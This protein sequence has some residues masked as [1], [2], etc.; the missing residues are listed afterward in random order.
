MLVPTS[1]APGDG[2][3]E[4]S[5]ES[6]FAHAVP[7]NEKLWQAVA[8][9]D[10]PPG[11]GIRW[12]YDYA[13]LLAES[14]GKSSRIARLLQLGESMQDKDARSPTYGNFRWYWRTDKVT[15][16]NAVEFVS[17]HMIP[18]WITHRRTLDAASRTAL[19]RTLRRAV[20][21]CLR[22][23]VSSSY[24]NIA[25]SNAANLI[26]L[27]EQ[28]DRKDALAKGLERLDAVCLTTWRYGICEYGS[29]TY[30][31]VDLDELVLLD[32]YVR[33][34]RGRKAAEAMLEMFWTD[35]ALNFFAP[36]GLLGGSQSRSYNY[37]CGASDFLDRHLAQAGWVKGRYH[38]WTEGKVLDSPERRFL[39]GSAW[40]DALPGPWKPP[41]KLHEIMTGQYPR[42]VFQRFGPRPAQ[43][44]RHL[45][46]R[47]IALGCSGKAYG[48]TDLPLTVDLPGKLT[49][50]R[51]YFIADGREDPYGKRRY[52]V[53]RAG[54]T[55]ALHL[56]PLWAAASGGNDALAVAFYPAGVINR[57]T[58]INLQ[59]HFV[60]RKP[61]AI[62]VDGKRRAVG[63]DKPLRIATGAILVLRYG[64]A[65]VAVAVPWA[66]D[67]HQRNAPIHLVDD[68]NPH[69][70]L[71]LT[72]DH[73][74][75][76]KAADASGAVQEKN[77]PLPGAAVWVRVAG[78]LDDSELETWLGKLARPEFSISERAMRFSSTGGKQEVSLVV[79]TPWESRRKV[80]ATPP[81]P[82]GILS[83]NGKELGRRIFESLDP[84]R[85]FRQQNA[86]ARPA[87]P[88][89]NDTD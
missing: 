68:G 60:V 51:C 62:T 71:R 23:E 75:R 67:R 40:L 56:T 82:D 34:R 11:C 78:G 2:G 36:G 37:P 47:D 52:A 10:P 3:R 48:S 89:R 8:D 80:H 54:H 38:H 35:I 55:K 20:D 14:G 84:I 63:R 72:V 7:R 73:F 25:L 41:S 50:S 39:D 87:A 65:A 66:T 49:E 15:D 88:K 45:V 81:P 4:F 70:V 64:T 32:K 43:W 42:D 6:F 28:F 17:H 12:I 46:Y 59:S 16:L 31:G 57:K 19:E 44:R 53:G 58:V 69:G 26:L 33:S 24:T 30:Y 5:R 13:L 77:R 1:A 21:G 9:S 85:R 86:G 83:L 29:P 22:H 27:G 74:G 61:D 79:T 76:A 18:L